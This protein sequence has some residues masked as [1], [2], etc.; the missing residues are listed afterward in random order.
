MIGKIKQSGLAGRGGAGFPVG[1]KWEAV[2]NAPGKK[3]FVVC[4]ASEGE[5]GTF[6]DKYILEN[7]PERV[8]EGISL[9]LSTVDAQE[10]YVFL[11][12]DYYDNF[13]NKLETIIGD[14]PIK[15][16]RNDDGY[17]E[18][19]ETVLINCIEGDAKEPKRKPPY[20]T[21]EGLW[22]C[23][24][25]IN[26][27]ETFF[28]VSEICHEEYDGSRFYSISGDV[29]KG[30][31]YKFHTESLI[32]DIL[33]RSGN[34]PSK[35]FFVQVGGGAGG[36]ILLSSELDRPVSGCASIIV[37]EK[38]KADIIGMMRDW[39]EFFMEEN[40]DRCVPCREGIYR[41]REII[42]ERGKLDLASLEEIF[43][44]LENS[45][46]CPLGKGVPV[47]FRS[48]INKILR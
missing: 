36:E 37:Y 30:G 3:K 13:K 41:I 40:C 34:Y 1:L 39:A 48:M 9:A 14:L 19:E 4:N 24:T 32:V 26:N 12:S 29:E 7:F 27:L 18:G 46:F 15:L 31:I 20:P 28:A 22:G 42:D 2:K 43:F 11:R 44:A 10:A 5:P 8:I 21:E 25:L 35:D 33:Q 38:D 23:P 16:W 45:S 47:P 6:K 17:L